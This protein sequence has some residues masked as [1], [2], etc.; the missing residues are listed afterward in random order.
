MALAAHDD[1]ELLASV[2]ETLD[3]RAW[4]GAHSDN[5]TTSAVAALEGG[6]VLFFPQL[7]FAL[8]ESERRFLVP[9]VVE[10]GS[11]NVAFDPNHNTLKHAALADG[12]RDELAL[13]MARYA[14]QARALVQALAPA[15]GDA[16]K[17]GRTSFRPAEIRGRP[18]SRRK[19]DTLLHVDAFPASPLGD[20][21]ILRL[22]TNINPQG[23]PREWR[24]G[25]PFDNVARRFATRAGAPL[26]G[27]AMLQK[28]LGVTKGT[29]THYDHLMLAIH[30]GMKLDESYQASVRFAP[31]DFPPGSSWLVFTDQV[32]HAAMG[33]Q[34]LLE[35]T[36]YLPVDAMVEPSASPL[37]VLEGIAGKKLV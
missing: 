14:A 19:D 10:E 12:E 21:R 13:M 15:Y 18:A 28:A 9:E 2:L 23:K 25:E 11:K 36:F 3:V 29:R 20:K 8:S 4:D 22:F 37:R 32:S 33:G 7:A 17:F 26:P 27:S 5:L 30:D 6:K 16:L 24:L 31:F 1:H 35:Q 34:H